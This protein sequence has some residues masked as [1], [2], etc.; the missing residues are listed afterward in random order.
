MEE[1]EVFNSIF[2]KPSWQWNLYV[3]FTNPFQA[4]YPNSIYIAFLIIKSI[5][6]HKIIYISC[7]VLTWTKSGQNHNK[8]IPITFK[9]KSHPGGHY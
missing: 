9:W 1:R 4:E 5:W 6:P 7:N 3:N 2:E 8:S